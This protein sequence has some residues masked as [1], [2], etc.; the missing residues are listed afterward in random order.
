M[1]PDLL[2]AAAAVL[3]GYLVL[4]IIGFGS[5][6]VMV[7][8]LAWVWPLPQVVV[9]A[10]LLDIPA[11]ILFGGLNRREVDFVA[12]RRLL[13]GMA[14]GSAAG[15]ALQGALP[16][17]WPLFGLGVYI[18]GVGLRALLR[19]SAAR[20]TGAGGGAVAGF[21]A[22]LIELMFATA[23][24]VV[25]AWLHRRLG[26]VY[27]VRATTPVAMAVCAG[28]AVAVLSVQ[29][30]LADRQLWLRW[31]AFLCIAAAGVALGHRLARYIPPAFLARVVSAMLVAS[32]L[33]LLARSLA[34]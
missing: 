15:L 30:T 7:P 34:A 9:L 29:G 5:A 28:I 24:P 14:V 18:A 32:G 3:A 20:P 13:P 1:T 27:A 23:G 21:S 25:L 4:G 6:L 26:S 10:L 2:Y 12:L 22:G 33:S 31:A 8:L 19:R 16:P 17:Q 11:S